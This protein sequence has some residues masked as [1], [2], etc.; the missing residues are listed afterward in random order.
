LQELMSSERKTIFILYLQVFNYRPEMKVEYNQKE[1]IL[2]I[3]MHK[4]L[5]QDIAKDLFLKF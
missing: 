4:S 2:K 1:N 3:H 5:L